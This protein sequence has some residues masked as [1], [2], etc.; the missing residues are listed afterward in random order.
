MIRASF[1]AAAAA[2]SIGTL[3]SAQVPIFAMNN[4]SGGGTGPNELVR[5][6]SN[7]PGVVTTIGSSGVVGGFTGLD[8]AGPGGDLYGWLGFGGDAGLHR[9]NLTTGAATRITPVGAGTLDIQD[10]SWD[11][12]NNRMVAIRSN[13]TSTSL[14]LVNL[15]T[16]ATT[17][18]GAIVGLPAGALSVGLAHDSQGNFYV[19]DLVSDVIYRGA[20]GGLS[21]SNFFSTVINANFSQ[22]MTIDWSRGDQGYHAAIGNSPAFF[23][24]L[25]SF[26]TTGS[27]S[28]T[29]VGNFSPDGTFPTFEGGDLAI[30]P[31]SAPTCR[32]DLNNDGELTFDDIQFFVSLYNAN[33]PRADFNNDQEWTFDDIQLFISLY[34]A[35]C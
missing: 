26:T 27:G 32:P 7:A 25:Y 28:Y 22:G 6:N 2:L 20:S 19:H 14:E 31:V 24:R 16:G 18:L 17:S 29:L 5:F 11:P 4:L 13:A 9:M 21:V 30:A 3:A 35:G 34:N 33:D 15:T 12:R 1:L 8:F 10:M 23:S